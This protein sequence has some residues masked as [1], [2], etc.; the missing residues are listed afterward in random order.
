M[1]EE[2]KNML[3]QLV[4][5]IRGEEIKSIREIVNEINVD[6]GKTKIKV[7]A[8]EEEV[9][10]LKKVNKSLESKIDSFEQQSKK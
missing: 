5:D 2:S 9:S 4:E 8:M 7:D 3:R 10:M 6:Y 1:D